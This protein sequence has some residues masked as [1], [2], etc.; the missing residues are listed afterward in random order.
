MKKI[1][2]KLGNKQAAKF[3]KHLKAEHPKYSKNL[4]IRK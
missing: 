2:I 1:I 4:K 3:S